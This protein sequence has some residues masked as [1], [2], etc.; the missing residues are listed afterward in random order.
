[1]GET[2]AFKRG[3]AYIDAGQTQQEYT[4]TTWC[5]YVRDKVSHDIDKVTCK[6][7]LRE[8]VKS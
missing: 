1:M 4:H 8:I 3:P 5:G 7:C 6:L 2:H